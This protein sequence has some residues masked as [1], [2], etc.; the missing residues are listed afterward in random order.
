MKRRRLSKCRLEAKLLAAMFIDSYYRP[1]PSVYMYQISVSTRR[2]YLLWAET[3]PSTVH[4]IAATRLK[5]RSHRMRC[6]AVRHR[7]APHRNASNTSVRTKHYANILSLLLAKNANYDE[8]ESTFLRLK[9]VCYYS[10]NMQEDEKVFITDH[11]SGSEALSAGFLVTFWRHI[12]NLWW[13]L[14]ITSWVRSMLIYRNSEHMFNVFLA[15]VW[16]VSFDLLF[17]ENVLTNHERKG[18]PPRS[19]YSLVLLTMT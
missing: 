3:L 17:S 10:R 13:L 19:F 18:L 9:R 14:V 5:I 6:G 11:S 12:N 7:N 15:S 2:Y 1:P 16:D 4:P 8:K